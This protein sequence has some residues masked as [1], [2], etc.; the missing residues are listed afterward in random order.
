MQGPLTQ[1][2]KPLWEADLPFVCFKLPQA[3]QATVYHQND[4]KL[5]I[6]DQ[7]KAEGFIMAPF[8]YEDEIFCIPNRFSKVFD[9]GAQQIT[10]KTAIQVKYTETEKS[11]F[12]E[13]IRLAKKRLTTR[14]CEKWYYLIPR[15]FRQNVI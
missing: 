2:L 13:L 7:L 4:E 3:K 1:F 10:P 9:L 15:S 11:S 8:D 12:E 14:D 5:H 6:A